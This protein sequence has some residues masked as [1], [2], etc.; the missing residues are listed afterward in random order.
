MAFVTEAMKRNWERN[1]RL[2]EAEQVR[3]A[4]KKYTQDVQ[5]ATRPPDPPPEN[6]PKN[7]GGFVQDFY[8][9]VLET[10]NDTGEVLSQGAN[11]LMSSIYGD[12]DDWSNTNKKHRARLAAGKNG[13]SNTQHKDMLEKNLS[14]RQLDNK[15]QYGKPGLGLNLSHLTGDNT[16]KNV[17]AYGNEIFGLGQGPDEPEARGHWS[18]GSAYDYPEQ[19]ERAPWN[20]GDAYD[21]GEEIGPETV[22][23]VIPT[24]EVYDGFDQDPGGYEAGGAYD[25]PVRGDGFDQ[26]PSDYEGMNTGDA[27]RG[28]QG[29]R[30][31]EESA[32]RQESK[33]LNAVILNPDT[34]PED[35]EEAKQFRKKIYAH[36]SPRETALAKE[37]TGNYWIDPISGVAINV[38]AIEADGQRKSNWLMIDKLPEHARPYFMA[39]FG[40]LDEEDV[41]GMP[42]DPKLVIAEMNM[43]TK[44]LELESLEKRHTES[45][46]VQYAQITGKNALH[47][48]NLKWEREKY[49]G[50]SKAQQEELQVQQY[51]QIRKDVD[52]MFKNGQ[53]ESGMLLAQGLNIPYVMDPVGFWKSKA[54]VSTQNPVFTRA[55]VGANLENMTAQTAGTKYNDKKGFYWNKLN[56]IET[57]PGIGKV[58][59]FQS[60][61]KLHGIRLWDQLTDAERAKAGNPMAW[62][63][64]QRSKVFNELLKNDPVFKYLHNNLNDART[65]ARLG[66]RGDGGGTGKK[67]PETPAKITKTPPKITEKGSKLS[68][69]S[70]VKELEG[71]D[72]KYEFGSGKYTAELAGGLLGLGKWDYD[73]YDSFM[74]YRNSKEGLR[75]I[76]EKNL[77]PGKIKKKLAEAYKTGKKGFEKILAREK[78]SGDPRFT[79]IKEASV[80]YN[81]KSGIFGDR[82]EGH[83]LRNDVKYYISRNL[84]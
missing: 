43:Q 82:R 62:N 63:N 47:A 70:P 56:E 14:K 34:P 81:K 49:N 68:E 20:T 75:E 35:V 2:N 64:S 42:I 24:A 69:I 18:E 7:S 84:K 6:P 38:D 45:T 37:E 53:Y 8:D 26:A 3:R 60:K 29:G 31:A 50:L 41:D 51:N 66:D 55:L 79:S 78:K 71:I 58:T 48:S 67:G 72:T 28:E 5:D 32:V 11:S 77:G 23:T 16:G 65:A 13:I 80:F 10:V 12:E 73:Q 54:K 83:E 9:T 57:E 30:S 33:E 44:K 36:L 40:Y 17:D 1:R 15:N 25:E 52:L 61:A 22:E 59:Y 19:G 27:G 21:M 74:A 76:S 46:G 39:K 4:N